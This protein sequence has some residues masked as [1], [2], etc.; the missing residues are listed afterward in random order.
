MGR[1]TES[2]KRQVRQ[3]SRGGACSSMGAGCRPSGCWQSFGETSVAWLHARSSPSL[4]SFATRPAIFVAP[5]R[6]TRELALL[7]A[8][9]PRPDDLLLAG[10]DHQQGRPARDQHAFVADSKRRVVGRDLL[11]KIGR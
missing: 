6:G 11:L 9:I 1:S 5:H 2:Q 4:P 8:V 10:I 7:M 3:W